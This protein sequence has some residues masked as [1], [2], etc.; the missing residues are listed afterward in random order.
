MHPD[1]S[2]SASS[3][4]DVLQV[5]PDSQCITRR[6]PKTVNPTS[7]SA[8]WHGFWHS[9]NNIYE[10]VG[11]GGQVGGGEALRCKGGEPGDEGYDG[12]PDQLLLG[13]PEVQ[14]Y[15]HHLPVPRQHELA[16]PL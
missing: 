6:C 15:L 5:S 4:V 8:L 1:S 3:T 11:A 2:W 7:H 9:L 14:N 16:C 10:V 12:A 13:L